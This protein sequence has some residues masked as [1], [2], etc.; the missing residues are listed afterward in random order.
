MMDHSTMDDDLNRIYDACGK[1]PMIWGGDMAWEAEQVVDYATKAWNEGHIVTLMWHVN[2]PFDKGFVKFKEQVQGK[3]TD[4]E[5][6]D[7]LTPGTEMNDLWCAQVDSISNYL[8]VLKDR[9]IPVLWRPYHENNGEWFWWGWRQGEKGFPALY[10]MLY[11]RMVNHNHLD[12]LLWVWNA[13]APREIPGDTALAYDLFFPGLDYVDVL[14]TDVYNRDWK[15]S[16]H[17][18]LLDLARGKLIALGEIGNL[19]TPQDLA[20]QNK[21]AWFMIWTGFTSTR[22]NQPEELKAVFDLPQVVN[23]PAGQ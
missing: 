19:P 20:T 15:Q 5:W 6:E 10:R 4:Q 14:A 7:L 8:R 3:L 21:Y 1:V 13:N 2:R 16:H 11:D 9:N 12:N 23:F 17:D 22:W 18:E